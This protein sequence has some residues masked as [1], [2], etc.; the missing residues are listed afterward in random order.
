MD[1]K[2]RQLADCEVPDTT[3]QRDWVESAHETERMMTVLEFPHNWSAEIL[4]TPPLIAPARQFTYPQQIAGEED[5]LARGALQLMVRPASGGTFLATCALGFTDPAMPTGVFACPNADEMCA[6]AGG[7]AYVI[8]TAQPEHCTH[9]ALKPVVE[10]R[11]LVAQKL[12]LFVGFHSMMAWGQ[13]RPGVGVGAAELGGSSHHQ[14][15]WRC[16]A[17]HRMESSD[18]SRGSFSLDLLTGQHQGGGFAQPPGSQKN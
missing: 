16:A 9:I 7:Y 15:R 4:K 17:R 3:E 5:A 2:S 14:H 18:G 1:D 6:V 11:L 13:Q 12:L 10:V 8:D